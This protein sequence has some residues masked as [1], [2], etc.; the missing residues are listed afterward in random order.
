MASDAA[1]SSQQTFLLR[2]WT[3]PEELFHIEPSATTFLTSAL[4]KWLL[5]A[6]DD[7]VVIVVYRTLEPPHIGSASTEGDRERDRERER[8]GER[9]RESG[10]M[11]QTTES[12]QRR[13]RAGG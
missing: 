12:S 8:E 4:G 3:T 5:V 13:R 9:E 2:C 7:D 6:N 1:A 10:K 11:P